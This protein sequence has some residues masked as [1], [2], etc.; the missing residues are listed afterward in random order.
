MNQKIKNLENIGLSSD[1]ILQL[2]DGKA[3]LIL[4]TDLAKI[5]NIDDILKPYGACII[6]YLTRKNYGHW[7]CLIKLDDKTLE[8]FDP[9]GFMIDE[10]LDWNIDKNF[11]KFSKQDYPHLTSLLYYSPYYL[12]YNQYKF[13]KKKNDI[14]T[15]GR[16]T[17][18]RILLRNLSLD[19]YYN[20]ILSMHKD[21]DYLVTLLTSFI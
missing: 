17:A 3:N 20:L 8:F 21:P 13:Q 11:R 14:K 15:C 5:T 16:H 2:I 10:E 9:Y 4:Y 6:L 19:E 12:T 7:V 1:E 18:L